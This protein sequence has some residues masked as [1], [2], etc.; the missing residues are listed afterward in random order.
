MI[1][2][3]EIN[4]STYSLRGYR[5]E[6]LNKKIE[7]ITNYFLELG[8]SKKDI[9]EIMV[10]F[11]GICGYTVKNLEEKIKAL[12]EFGYTKKLIIKEIKGNPLLFATSS[13]ESI[14]KKFEF[15]KEFL[16]QEEIRKVINSFPRIYTIS[17]LKLNKR[18]SDLEEIG[19]NR[20]NIKKIILKF[21]Q[22]FSFSKD[23]IVKKI[24]EL[25]QYGYSRS[26][27]LNMTSTFPQLFSL[28]EER[29]NKRINEFLELDYT[30]EETLKITKFMPNI[31]GY[32]SETL[33]EKLNY[34][35]VIGVREEIIE[36]PYCLIHGIDLIRAKYEF[37]KEKG[38]EIKA[39][40][41]KTSKVFYS[42]KLFQKIYGLTKEELL[43]IYNDHQLKDNVISKK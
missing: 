33:K 27:V 1:K 34:Y 36:N 17:T 15:F 23:K 25:E 14:N 21:P 24:D 13:K 42:N 5:K 18:I 39:S 9:E 22:I 31:Y 41:S 28:N 37:L 38:I 6:S 20:K 8:L 35:D 3:E 30:R 16:T 29:I 7:E 32:N 43:N 40:D 11:P 26:D 12:E 19:Y 4:L 10:S 2:E